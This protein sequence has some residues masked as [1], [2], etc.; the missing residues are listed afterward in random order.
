MKTMSD[1]SYLEWPFFEARHREMAAALEEWCGGLNVDHG[2]VD[3]AC[4]GLVRDL[5]AGG[6]LKH[7]GG[8]LD[9]RTL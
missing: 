4:L 9:V 2:D 1:R 8:A 5:G 3:A 6:W 7:S